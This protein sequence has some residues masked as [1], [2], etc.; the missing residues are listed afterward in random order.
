MA[1]NRFCALCGHE[2]AKGEV[3]N[4]FSYWKCWVEYVDY[5][6]ERMREEEN[7]AKK[8]VAVDVGGNVLAQFA[9]DAGI[10]IEDVVN[11]VCKDVPENYSVIIYPF[12]ENLADSVAEPLCIAEVNGRLDTSDSFG[13][14]FIGDKDFKIQADLYDASATV[15]VAIVPPYDRSLTALVNATTRRAQPP[16]LC[17]GLKCKKCCRVI[18]LLIAWLYATD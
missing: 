17:V 10:T 8:I 18:Q 13:I 14:T 7:K 2:F 9:N 6:N 3:K 16:A 11:V 1:K 12:S 4:G 15:T 5:H